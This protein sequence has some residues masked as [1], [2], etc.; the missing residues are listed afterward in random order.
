VEEEEGV[1]VE[2]EEKTLHEIGRKKMIAMM[3]SVLGRLSILP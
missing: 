2:E 3:V 1:D